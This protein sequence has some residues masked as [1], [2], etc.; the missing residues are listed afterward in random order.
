MSIGTW[1]GLW[2][3]LILV[4]FVGMVAWVWSDRRKG[5]YEQAGRIPLQEDNEP[6]DDSRAD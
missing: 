6:K 5:H 4:L 2:S 3:L 1:H